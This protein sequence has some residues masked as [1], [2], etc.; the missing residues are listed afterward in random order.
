MEELEFQELK[1]NIDVIWE[2]IIKVHPE[3]I[4]GTTGEHCV[5]IRSIIR[6]PNK[7]G[8]CDKPGR[9]FH[10]WKSDERSK[11]RFIDWYEQHILNKG[12]C[13]FISVH[14]FDSNI[15]AIRENG[16]K[17]KKYSINSFNQKSCRVLVADLDNV[18]REENNSFDDDMKKLKIPFQSIKTSE[19]GYQKRIYLKEIIHDEYAVAKFTKLLF[20]KGYKVDTKLI[21]RGQVVRLNGSINNK[22]FSNNFPNR[23][24]QFYVKSII[25]AYEKISIKDLWRKINLLPT[26]KYDYKIEEIDDCLIE[27]V[28]EVKDIKS[29]EYDENYFKEMY[30][31][32]IKPD[33]IKNLQ[34]PIKRMLVDSKEGYTDAVILFLIPY[35]KNTLKLSYEEVYKIFEVW[36]EI[37]NYNQ[38][39]KIERIYYTEYKKGLGAYSKELAKKYGSIDFR[40]SYDTI[41]KINDNTININ[42]NIFNKDLYIALDKTALKIF[43]TLLFEYK[44]SSKITWSLSEVIKYN[45]ISKPTA[46]KALKELVNKEFISRQNYYKGSG[47]ESDYTL[48]KKYISLKTE[49]RIEFTLSE[50]DRIISKLKGNEIKVYIYMKYMVLKSIDVVYYGNQK[51]ISKN[52]GMSQQTVSDILISLCKKRFINIEKIKNKDGTESNSYTLII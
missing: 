23:N 35:F 47:K 40:K 1:E 30:S 29:S 31:R 18:S 28:G 14:N 3:L 12:A 49:R 9:S 38:L 17:Y 21:N 52:I 50:M 32:V 51:D 27:E 6:K 26:L 5:E 25:E 13:L 19:N 8:I 36:A 37:N 4:D 44:A 7:K 34:K 42:P 48:M 33:Y 11:K 39:D 46:I 45:G 24:K 10:L 2:D 20:C 16:K 22:C 15:E 43:M 41:I